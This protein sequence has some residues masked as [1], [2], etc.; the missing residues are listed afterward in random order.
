MEK[1]YDID[2]VTFIMDTIQ[3]AVETRS[4]HLKRQLLNT[5]E[6]IYRSAQ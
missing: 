3:K 5:Y 4:V 2:G 6:R 1:I